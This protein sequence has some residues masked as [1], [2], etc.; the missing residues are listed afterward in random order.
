MKINSVDNVSN[1]SFKGLWEKSREMVRGAQ[2]YTTYKDMVW[3]Y[4]PF[5][6]ESEAAVSCA[7]A[8]KVY[9]VTVPGINEFETEEITSAPK[10]LAKLSFTEKE[11]AEYKK[12]Y[13]K[14]LPES[15]V[16]IEKEL[17]ERDLSHYLNSR[18]VCAA[19]RLLHR[20]RII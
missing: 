3:Y 8:S 7:L 16:K 5:A 14:K 17:I 6:D 20:I 9:K 13:G 11:F 2:Y 12:F 19:K 4:H 10:A 18:L 15:M 1:A